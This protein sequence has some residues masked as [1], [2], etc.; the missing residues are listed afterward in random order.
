[1]TDL[2]LV[3]E[4]VET[5][6]GRVLLV[7]RLPKQ[8]GPERLQ[9]VLILP[10]FAEEMNKA[11]KA[12]SD[13][14]HALAARGVPSLTLDLFGTGDSEGEFEA[15]NWA[16]W[17]A[18]VEGVVRHVEGRGIGLRG[19]VGVRMGCLLAASWLKQHDREIDR[20]VFWQPLLRGEQALV[21]LLRTRQ[22]AGLFG[23]THGE[24]V[25]ALRGRLARGE[26][27]EAA[28][29]VLGAQLAE[30]LSSLDLVTELSSV[31]RVLSWFEVGS[32]TTATSV[33]SRSAAAQLEDK[34]VPVRVEQI[35]GAPF[36][37][38]TEIVRNAT[39]VDRTV[40]ALTA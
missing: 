6:A 16:R 13:L 28:G 3:A 30:D 9:G 15:A 22:L 14:S 8:E 5:A 25:S 20:A 31:C 4:F 39:L 36:W 1:L 2:P 33:A 7:A 18:N 21:Q 34:G 19:V 23:E 24:S 10:P 32:S 17:C 38:S 11:R 12:M 27:V 40:V 35:A 29:Y 26:S 37:M